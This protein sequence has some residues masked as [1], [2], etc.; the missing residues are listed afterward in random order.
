[1]KS[2]NLIECKICG[3][4]VEPKNLEKHLM[5]F[6]ELTWEDYFEISR[7]SSPSSSVHCWNCGA[8]RAYLSPWIRNSMILP[9]CDC[10]PSNRE[11]TLSL[12]EKY[13]TK[14][15]KDK[16]YQ[17]ILVNME[18]LHSHQIHSMPVLKDFLKSY[19]FKY[20]KQSRLIISYQPW[21]IPEIS[22]R[23]KDDI[24]IT[25]KYDLDSRKVSDMNFEVEL[26]RG[27]YTISLPENTIYDIYHHT[28]YSIFNMKEYSRK[29][30][31][32]KFQDQTCIKFY[33]PINSLSGIK[34]ILKLSYQGQ[35]INS[36]SLSKEDQ[37]YLKLAILRNS[38]IRDLVIKIYLEICKYTKFI[39]DQAFIHNYVSLNNHPSMNEPGFFFSWF[40]RDS[41]IEENINLCII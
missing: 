35:E 20:T 17:N 28:R 8:R 38:S 18:W 37:N 14:I 22:E 6:H 15:L 25:H 29:A 40:P 24:L 10:D 9:C 39:D 30:K 16:Y 2:S 12:I 23:N 19:N 3:T 13:M 1:M 36:R 21:T 11:N 31:R 27:T 33:D 26:S 34:S 5:E 7:L 32:L 41:Y 4:R